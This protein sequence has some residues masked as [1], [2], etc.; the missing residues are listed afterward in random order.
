MIVWGGIEFH[1]DIPW[2][3]EGYADTGS[4]Y[5]PITDAWTQMSSSGTPSKR[6]AHTMVWTGTEAIIW[7]GFVEVNDYSDPDIPYCRN[8]ALGSGA[9]YDPDSNSWTPISATILGV[10]G[11]SCRFPMRSICD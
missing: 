4:R 5:D 10:P 7:G 9:S 1:G 6:G 3:G 11:G 2:C 8:E